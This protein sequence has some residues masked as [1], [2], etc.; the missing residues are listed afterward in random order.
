MNMKRDRK[1][2]IMVMPDGGPGSRTIHIAYKWLRVLA[3]GASLLAFALTVMAGS[4]WYL[5]ARASRVADLE[6]QLQAVA[7]DRVRVQILARQLELIE[8]QYGNIRDLFGTSGSGAGSD[9][10]LP[11]ASGSRRGRGAET[12][13]ASGASLPS[14]W[15]L[16]EK[17]FVTQ[18]L[19]EGTSGDDD[20]PGVDIAVPTD[21]YIRAAGGGT[22]VDLGED[23][24]YGRF[25]KID[26][27]GGYSTMYAHASLHLVALGQE[28]REREVIGLS[29]S[30]G[31]STAPHLH[32]EILL[33]DEAVD[34]LTMVEQ[35]S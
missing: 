2:T 31:R 34:P 4:W 10:W 15:P 17:G 26:H 22:V 20:H 9:V 30:T 21:S 32:F 16:G 28:V 8:A 24:V 13:P 12:L 1:L 14:V 27:G 29:G 33:N 35:P 3:A 6:F 5:A 25:I 19:I 11:P 18:A 23:R 7:G